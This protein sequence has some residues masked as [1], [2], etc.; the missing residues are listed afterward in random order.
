[1]AT[2]GHFRG[3]AGL[4]GRHALT[5]GQWLPRA[6]LCAGPAAATG[7]PGPDPVPGGPLTPVLGSPR[8]SRAG[9]RWR[10]RPSVTSAAPCPCSAWRSRWSPSPCSRES[11]PAHPCPRV[12]GSRAALCNVN[13]PL[14][15]RSRELANART[16][17]VTAGWLHWV[18]APAQTW[19]AG[20]GCGVAG[21]RGETGACGTGGHWL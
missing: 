18:T 8:S 9:T 10:C 15:L 14:P 7:T 3:A 4:R 6:P 21:E 5:T 13:A 2:T 1:M 20:G 11:P 17:H 19:G 12:P 16:L